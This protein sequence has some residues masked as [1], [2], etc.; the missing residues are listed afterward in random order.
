ML[1]DILKQIPVMDQD[2]VIRDGS[3]VR[4]FVHV[5]DVVNGVIGLAKSPCMGIYN[6]GT[7]IGTKAL[8]LARLVLG[9]AGQ[10]NR[11]VISLKKEDSKSCIVIDNSRLSSASGW[12]P[13]KTLEEGV[14][15]LVMGVIREN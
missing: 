3:S 8:D 6:L 10:K 2:L 1:S 14:R 5:D 11:S 15:D 12:S 13:D 4:D 7:G 9:L